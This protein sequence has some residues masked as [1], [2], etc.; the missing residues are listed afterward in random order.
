MDAPDLEDGHGPTARWCGGREVQL[1]WAMRHP[2]LLLIDDVLGHEEC[3]ALVRIAAPR[4]SRLAPCAA[5]PGGPAGP[6]ALHVPLGGPDLNPYEAACRDHVED[7]LHALFDW[8]RDAGLPLHVTRL[9][10]A[11]Q[12]SVPGAPLGADACAGAPVVG[13]LVC[14]LRVSRRGA[15]LPWSPAGMS[16]AARRGA[17]LFLRPGTGSGT[18]ATVATEGATPTAAPGDAT[19]IATKCFTRP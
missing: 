17:A 4:A 7:R 14:W 11:W 12:G 15:W 10:S 9:T 3:E 8:P 13:L 16:F 18:L 5:S 2:R 19:W 6:A 1:R